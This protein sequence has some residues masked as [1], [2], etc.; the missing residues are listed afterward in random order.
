[1]NIPTRLHCGEKVQNGKKKI[2]RDKAFSSIVVIRTLTPRSG[3][4]SRR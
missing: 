4:V 2:Q 1:L 3:G